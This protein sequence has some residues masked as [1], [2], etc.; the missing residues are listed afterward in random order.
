MSITVLHT[1]N[2]GPSHARNLGVDT[3][4]GE[5]I[6]F[7]DSD[8]WVEKD[9]FEKLYN[10]AKKYDAD[11]VKAEFCFFGKNENLEKLNLYLKKN[12]LQSKENGRIICY[13]TNN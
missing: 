12:S 7:V 4:Q 9:A 8:D 6:V 11:L 3:A 10:T 2:K 13:L 5:Y 1:E